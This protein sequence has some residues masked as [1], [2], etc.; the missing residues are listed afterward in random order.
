M[1]DYRYILEKGSKKHPCPECRKKTLVRYINTETG[2]YL[3]GMYGRCDREINCGYHVGP[4]EYF[5]NESLSKPNIGKLTFA[6]REN[7]RKLHIRNLKKPEIQN[8]FSCIPQD[9]FQ[10]SRTAYEG[11]SFVRYLLT[12]FNSRTVSDL[13][14][15]Y[16]IGTSKHWLGSAVFWQIDQQGRIRT[17]KIMQ[18]SPSTG[19]RVKKPF[20]HIAWVHKALKLPDFTLQQ[21]LFGSHLTDGNTKPLAVVESEKT[22]IIASIY[23]PEFIWLATGGLS[24]L[25]KQNIEALKGR[26][27]V[28]FPDLGAFDKWSEKAKELPGTV[29]VS[30]YLENNASEAD[31]QQ[32]YDIAD[33]LI[34]SPVSAFVTPSS[35]SD[36]T[37][38]E[39]VANSS[40]R[41][42]ENRMPEC[43]YYDVWT[44]KDGKEVKTLI[45]GPGGYPASWGEPTSA[46]E[47]TALLID[48]NPAMLSMINR[49]DLVPGSFTINTD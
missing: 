26:E 43:W 31:R 25:N 23:L 48:K 39:K 2:E 30:D 22:A 1:N 9:I 27:I 14:A 29:R 20:N 45:N 44:R 37:Q 21:C 4:K 40:N 8:E 3:P 38:G 41:E 35:L 13:I 46:K 7:L 12:I 28:L 34:Q 42:A 24:N 17:G 6:N 15:R 49:L 19:K 10:R 5:R 11:N 16:H 36:T 32:G 18:Y 47:A 33:Y